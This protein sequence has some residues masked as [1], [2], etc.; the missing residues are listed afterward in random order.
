MRPGEED[1][2]RWRASTMDPSALPARAADL[3]DAVREE[4]PLPPEAL[5][6]IRAERARAAAARG[7]AGLPVGLRFALLG[8]VVLASVATAKGTMLLWRYVVAPRPRRAR[9]PREHRLAQ[10]RTRSTRASRRDRAGASARRRSARSRPCRPESPTPKI[11]AAPAPPAA[12]ARPRPAGRPADDDTAT[13]AQL[14]ATRPLA[15]APKPRLRAARSPCWTSTRT[16]IRAACSRPRRGARGSRPSLPA[17]R[18][19]GGAAPARRSRAPF[20]GRLGAEQL[21]TRRRAARERGPLRRRAGATS[22]G[23][24]GPARSPPP[25]PPRSSARCTAAPYCLGHLG[26]EDRARADLEAYQRR[27]PGGAICDRSG[28]LLG[29]RGQSTVTFLRL[30]T[31][32]GRDEET[33]SPGHL[34]LAFAVSVVAGGCSAHNVVGEVA[35]GGVAGREV[36]RCPPARPARP[37]RPR[38]TTCSGGVDDD[39]DGFADCLDTECDGQGVRR[40]ADVQRRRVPQAV[41]RRR[42]QLRPRAA[43]HPERQGHDPRGHGDH[44]LRARR[45]RGSTTAS[46]PS[47]PTGDWL[48][49]A[50]GEVGV[51]NG[52]YRCAGDRVFQAREADTANAFDCSHHA[53]AT[54]PATTTSARRPKR[55]SA[56]SS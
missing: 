9:R 48:I 47:P 17:R 44:R 49:G 15:P 1:P 34:C 30:P 45:R 35:D 29:G 42:R 3:V 22:T 26:R 25:R 24:S 55:R 6:R 36:A 27:Y 32:S 33:R 11:T 41:R 50:S 8:G 20:A 4:P 13:E 28:R 19:P 43:A 16:R 2:L 31:P 38:E 56:T 40:R 46:T 5:A 18:P 10:D 37:S 14:L 52:I 12:A 21:L 23:C 7:A 53:A 54:T 51:K 39:C